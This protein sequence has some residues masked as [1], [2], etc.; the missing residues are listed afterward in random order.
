MQV[1]QKKKKKKNAYV[2]LA[3]YTQLNV[4]IYLIL[5]GNCFWINKRITKFICFLKF[6]LL[7]ITGSG[8]STLDNFSQ[9]SGLCVET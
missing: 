5:K 7:N 6:K 9:C 2:Q 1:L 4:D 8:I 3:F